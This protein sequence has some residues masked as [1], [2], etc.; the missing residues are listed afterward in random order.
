[1]KKRLQNKDGLSIVMGIR[2]LKKLV[3]DGY[4][5]FYLLLSGG[6]AYSR[7]SIY[8]EGKKYKIINWIDDSTQILT[9]GQMLNKKYT[10]IREGISKH[11]FIVNLKEKT[12]RGLTKGK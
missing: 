5:E 3:A 9:A 1:M 7:K 4:F 6:A 2:D 12:D 11:A 8:T 10:H